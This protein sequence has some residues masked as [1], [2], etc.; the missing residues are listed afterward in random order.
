MC[1]FM[2]DTALSDCLSAA[3]TLHQ[4][5]TEY[6]WE[7]SAYTVIP[8]A[9]SSDIVGIRNKIEALIFWAL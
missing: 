4:N 8:S 9:P 3:V 5:V 1:T 2:S 7:G 6:R